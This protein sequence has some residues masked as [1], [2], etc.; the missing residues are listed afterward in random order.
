MLQPLGHD[1]KGEYFSLCHGCVGSFS[2]TQDVGKLRNLGN[3]PAIKFLLALN[4][5]I[6]DRPLAG[7]RQNGNVPKRCDTRDVTKRF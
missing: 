6:H 7:N 2:V 3:P 1:A 5:E 4:T